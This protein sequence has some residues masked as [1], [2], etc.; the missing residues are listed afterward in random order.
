MVNDDV[1]YGFR[2]RL[3]SLAAELGN[4]REACRIFGV[5]RSTYYR[6]RRP[7][8]ARSS[9]CPGR[10]S[11]ARRGCPTRRASSPSSGSSHSAPTQSPS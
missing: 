8:C 11:A 1:L 10:E 9:R 6:S 5:H 3:F 2:L 4:V 7:E